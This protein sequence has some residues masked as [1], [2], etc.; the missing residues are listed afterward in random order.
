MYVFTYL[1][2]YWH[3]HMV[4]IHQIQMNLGKHLAIV[5]SCEEHHGA[6]SVIVLI[7]SE[8]MTRVQ[9]WLGF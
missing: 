3:V 1:V 2:S 5:I 8:L 9:L 4:M 6:G 7:H